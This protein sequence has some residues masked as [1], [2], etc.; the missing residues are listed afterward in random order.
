MQCVQ[1]RDPLV[2]H[3][4]QLVVGLL[5]DG[6]P[7]AVDLELLSVETDLGLAALLNVALE[8]RGEKFRRGAHMTFAHKI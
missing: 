3:D 6:H 2:R 4:E 7:L 8:L 5:Q 1:V